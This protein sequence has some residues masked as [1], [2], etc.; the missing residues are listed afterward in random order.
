MQFFQ[1]DQIRGWRGGGS[2]IR[3]GRRVLAQVLHDPAALQANLPLNNPA[4]PAGSVKVAAD[5]SVAA[6]VPAQRALSWQLTDADGVAVVRERYWLTFQPGEIR[7]CGSC[8]GLSQFDQAGNMAPENPP[9]ALLALLNDWKP[10]SEPPTHFLY[11][12]AIE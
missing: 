7:V 9:Q 10:D 6:F 2:D 3:P 4:A 8:H 1:A 12:P 5:G 11:L